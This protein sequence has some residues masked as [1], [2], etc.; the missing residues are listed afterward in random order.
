MA[1]MP[2]LDL[3][4]AWGD[5]L[6]RRA[7]LA[8][9]LE[10]YAA[11]IERWASEA[12]AIRPLAWS[13][14]E[15]RARWAL[16]VPL[17]ADALPPLSA[18]DLEDTLGEAMESLAAAD[19]TLAPGLQRL[20][21]AWDSG[22]VVPES[23]LPA[24]GRLGSGAAETASGLRP[25]VIGFLACV[26]LRPTLDAYVAPVRAHLGAGDWMLG[27]CPFCGAPPGFV[28]VVEGGH[29][30]LACHFC[31][32]AWIFAKLRCPFCGIEGTKDMARLSAEDRDAGYLIAG[33]RQCHAYLKELD[34]R[35]RW[36]GGPAIV[37]DWGSPH[38]DVIAHRQGFWR[39][40]PSLL[41]LAAGA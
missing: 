14:E 36:N 31:G 21:E 17:L 38:L 29:R 40:V 10:A 16:G 24:R 28:D 30:R 1:G 4:Q 22:D 2:N 18:E 26:T 41:Q 20:A 33:C 32:S 39:G 25:G 5:L 13:S 9:S 8:P 6:R 15:C 27:V 23:L 12:P 7:A 35:E 19:E 37:E 34:R 3:R 11:I